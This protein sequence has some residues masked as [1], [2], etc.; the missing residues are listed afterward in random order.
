[1]HESVLRTRV[2]FGSL[3][4]WSLVGC[5][6]GGEVEDP[7]GEGGSGGQVSSMGGDDTR[8]GVTSTFGGKSAG[9]FVGSGGASAVSG[10]TTSLGGSAP[11]AGGTTSSGGT[12]SAG[13]AKALGGATS[14]GGKSSSGGATSAG[15]KSSSGG[16]MS[17]GG[18]S[19]SGGAM[20][21]GGA[22]SLGGA[23]S[24]GGVTAQGGAAMGGSGGSPTAL[25]LFTSQSFEGS[26]VDGWQGRGGATLS[27]STD[28]QH[29][30]EKSLRVTGRTASWHGVEYDVRSVVT[31]GETYNVSVWAKLASGTAAS[32]LQLTR[33]LQGCGTTSYVPLDTV[34]SATDA[35]WV[36]LSGTLMIAASCV[37]TKLT[38]YVESA[39]ATASFFVDDTRMTGN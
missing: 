22:P 5:A 7:R 23:P 26:S 33:E 6:T 18:K 34:A 30:G 13:G 29:T 16:A 28:Q 21:S 20:T 19:S 12:S 35:D 32:S 14:A 31:P 2:L 1:M 27:V 36:E 17:A 3:L 38:V 39:N 11:S 4:A 37:P 8:G 24:A 9:G 15:G 25:N 10:G